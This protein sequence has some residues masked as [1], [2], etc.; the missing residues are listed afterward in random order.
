MIPEMA[1]AM[2][3]SC[4]SCSADS[5]NPNSG[6]HASALEEDPMALEGSGRSDL[7][8]RRSQIPHDPTVFGPLNRIRPRTRYSKWLL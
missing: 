5:Y 4:G 2:H 6:V 3:P 7:H 1:F 8:I